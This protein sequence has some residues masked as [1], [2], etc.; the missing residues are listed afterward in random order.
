MMQLRVANNLPLW[1][2]ERE[3]G[4]CAHESQC[5]SSTQRPPRR[6]LPVV[7]AGP[8]ASFT[9]RGVALAPHPFS[10]RAAFAS[11]G[12]KG[13]P[14]KH[15]C[16]RHAAPLLL[17]RADYLLGARKKMSS[18]SQVQ[19]CAARPAHPVTAAASIPRVDFPQPGRSY[20]EIA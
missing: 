4:V 8:T 9:A 15:L 19:G 16:W 10:S 14:R 7:G 20:A 3:M 5:E 6:H 13:T 11:S 17:F 18:D 1:S 12:L 2:K